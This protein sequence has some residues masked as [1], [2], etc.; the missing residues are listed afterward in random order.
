[1]SVIKVENN[2]QKEGECSKI[3][4]AAGCCIYICHWG[5]FSKY[6]NV[7][8]SNDS[9]IQYS[10]KDLEWDNKCSL[11]T[12]SIYIYITLTLKYWQLTGNITGAFW[13]GYNTWTECHN[14]NK[15]AVPTAS[16]ACPVSAP[17]GWMMKTSDLY[18]IDEVALP[19]QPQ[20]TAFKIFCNFS[21]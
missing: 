8:Q 3:W 15:A 19:S 10:S 21:G 9:I 6:C 18:N 14:T 20:A 11:P 13:Q 4:R 16:T 5:T 12:F 2:S 1:M 7:N 17:M